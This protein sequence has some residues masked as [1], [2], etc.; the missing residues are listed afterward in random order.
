MW[1]CPTEVKERQSLIQTKVLGKHL[2]SSLILDKQAFWWKLTYLRSMY[3]CRNWDFKW[4]LCYIS[5][6]KCI[7]KY[8][9]DCITAINSSFSLR[10]TSGCL[11]IFQRCT[12]TSKTRIIGGCFINLTWAVLIHGCMWSTVSSELLYTVNDSRSTS[13]CLCSCQVSFV[14]HLSA[15]DFDR[16]RKD[17][18]LSRL[19]KT[20]ALNNPSLV[21]DQGGA[22]LT[23]YNTIPVYTVNQNQK[24]TLVVL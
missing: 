19:R 23:I 2:S 16:R 3:M 9:H 13:C 24:Y 1:N 8:T 10:S 5:W 11:L 20:F 15:V 4:Q 18:V 6:V 14:F 7:R 17:G 21:I 12:L 22:S